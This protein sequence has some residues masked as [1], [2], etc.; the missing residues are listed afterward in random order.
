[1]GLGAL[2]KRALAAGLDA[3]TVCDALDAAADRHPVGWRLRSR[4]RPP[5]SPPSAPR[6]PPCV[7]DAQLAEEEPETEIVEVYGR[8]RAHAVIQAGLEDYQQHFGNLPELVASA[9]KD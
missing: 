5:P 2:Q 4:G 9:L 3:D 8:D 1:M 6:P 7:C